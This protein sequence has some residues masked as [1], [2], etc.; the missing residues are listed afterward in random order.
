MSFV[1]SLAAF[2]LFFALLWRGAGQSDRAARRWDEAFLMAATFWAGTAVLLAEG[3]GSVGALASTTMR[4]AW[5]VVDAILLVWVGV[6]WR[7]RSARF[8]SAWPALTRL[9]L[10]SLGILGVYLLALGAVAWSA[11][12]NNVDSLQYHMARVVHWAQQ[13]SLALYGTAYGP[14]IWNPPGA[15][16]LIL[17]LRLMAGDDR[18]A[19]FVQW[20]AYLAC[21]VGVWWTGRMFGLARPARWV[22]LAFAA[23]I[24]MAVLQ[25]TSTQNDL[26]AA[27]W[28]VAFAA[29]VVAN[30]QRRLSFV[31]GGALALAL[32]L[33]L[34]TKATFYVFCAPFLAWFVLSRPW[35]AT[36]RGS[37]AEILLVGLPAIVLNLGHA[38]RSLAM[39]WTPI[40]PPGWLP[41]Q[42]YPASLGQALGIVVLR[43][44]R[45]GLMNFASPIAALNEWITAAVSQGHAL[46]GLASAGPVVVWG[47]NHEDVAGS[48]VHALLLLV[49]G[50]YLI[51]WKRRL[52][53]TQ[54]YAL[55]LA[56][57]VVTLA[58]TTASAVHP[59]NIRFQLPALVAGAPLV[60]VVANGILR[61]RGMAVVAVALLLLPVPWVL[62]NDTRPI[63]GLSPSP[64]GMNLPCVLGCTRVGSVFQQP[65]TDVLF[66]NLP[67][68]EHDYQIVARRLKEAT[69]R[70]VGLRNDSSDSEYFLWWL[71]EAPQSGYHL[72]TIYTSPD[73]DR[74]IDRAF[75]PCVIVCTICGER[76]R[77]HGLDLAFEQ[78][79]IR[80]FLGDDFTWDEDG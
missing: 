6:V 63:F 80:V 37:L 67:H 10:V 45:I 21:L 16:I 32:G 62:F 25:S 70:N 79:A 24:P 53:Q 39:G 11:P 2:A 28:L 9:D 3:L 36:A 46:L 1:L 69:C 76:T 66:A 23:S 15:E 78:G 17:N 41:V 14:Q 74:L 29:F 30:R 47:W 75:K 60:A 50:L 51:V 56:I 55:C 13:G 54:V 49:A 19:N 57:G 27:A 68:L 5:I 12:P 7:R 77:L 73:L 4:T 40:G 34:L 20:F 33:G 31:D 61:P 71:L 48:P 44:M 26:M 72:E 52:R 58:A 22:A 38:V 35:K 59:W 18:L 8:S 65:K 64:G 43:L 42:A